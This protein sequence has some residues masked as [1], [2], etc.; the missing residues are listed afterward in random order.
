MYSL[1]R[2]LENGSLGIIGHL[3]AFSGKTDF[4]DGP[5]SCPVRLTRAALKATF[6]AA[7]RGVKALR[8]PLGGF[9]KIVTDNVTCFALRKVTKYLRKKHTERIR[10]LHRAS[11]A[12]Q[13]GRKHDP[14]DQGRS[15]LHKSLPRAAFSLITSIRESLGETLFELLGN[16]ATLFRY[17]YPIY[18]HVRNIYV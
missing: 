16:H 14:H 2:S 12:Q 4:G 13:P 3:R 1:Q 17:M 9:S 8:C 15:S 11:T 18:M 6:G 7:G 5:L 10:P